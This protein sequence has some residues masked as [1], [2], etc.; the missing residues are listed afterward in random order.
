MKFLCLRFIA[1]NFTLHE[2]CGLRFRGVWIFERPEGSDL[3]LKGSGKKYLFKNWA[4]LQIEGIT[5][6]DD[7][8]LLISNGQRQLFHLDIRAESWK[9]IIPKTEPTTQQ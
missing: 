9:P 2:I 4:L 6:M 5:W 8:T 3:F 1:R 7:Q